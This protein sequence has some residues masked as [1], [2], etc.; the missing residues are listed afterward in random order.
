[1]G[2]ERPF[3][4]LDHRST[5]MELRIAITLEQKY[6][7]KP[8]LG[9]IFPVYG[10]QTCHFWFLDNGLLRKKLRIHVALRST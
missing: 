4:L 6:P 9:R 3:Q 7:V 8:T 1:M 5:T 2:H 10:S